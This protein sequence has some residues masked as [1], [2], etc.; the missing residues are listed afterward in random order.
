MLILAAVTISII[1]NGGLFN[2]AKNAAT[3]TKDAA[4]DERAQILQAEYEAWKIGQ[5]QKGEDSSIEAFFNQKD[6]IYDPDN[7]TYEDT[8]GNLFTIS[9]DEKT[10]LAN[11]TD[12]TSKTDTGGN[13]TSGAGTDE[14]G[15]GDEISPEQR[16]TDAGWDPVIIADVVDGAPIPQGFTVSNKPDE[17]TV[18]GGLVITDAVDSDGNS[19]GNE[20]VWVPCTIDGA[21]GTAK[22]VKWTSSV[23]NQPT[24]G[25]TTDYSLPAGVTS[26]SYQINKYKGFYIARYEMGIPTDDSNLTTAL[27]TATAAA[28]NKNGKPV[29]KKNAIPWNYIDYAHAKP[30]AESMIST[31]S[32]QSGLIMGTQWD[33]MCKWLEISGYN[34]QTNSVGWGNYY[35]AV[36]TGF[37][38]YST[39][40]GASWVP[41]LNGTKNAG[42]SWLLKTG[43]TEYTKANNI[44]DVAGNLIECTNEDNQRKT[45]WPRRCL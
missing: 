16:V 36:V 41:S 24:A 8:N 30:N 45:C 23:N 21:N 28:R 11:G 15:G 40:G 6:G 29:S 34:V 2:Q 7:K 39:D 38:E 27:T 33:T 32:V 20:F 14:D 19:I 44:Y 10:I 43:A 5:Q 22:Y 42:H 12:N 13:D 17:D 25:F 35:N 31:A 18:A 9:D 3:L 1:I 26:E 37:N 4:A